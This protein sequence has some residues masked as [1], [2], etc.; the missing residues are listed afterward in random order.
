MEKSPSKRT[1]IASIVGFLIELSVASVG[2]Y[3][4]YGSIGIPL[5]NATGNVIRSTVT[6]PYYPG[7]FVIGVYLFGMDFSRKM[8]I[9]WPKGIRLLIYGGLVIAAISAP[10]LVFYNFYFSYT[11]VI[12]GTTY[13]IYPY[14]VQ[15]GIPFMI[16]LFV[17][18]IGW[19]VLLAS[20][21]RKRRT[22][23]GTYM[24]RISPKSQLGDRKK[25]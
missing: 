17:A 22:R 4:S 12:A 24:I 18:L 15:A 19:F 13:T 8:L 20:R 23:I 21:L 11:E 3:L 1:G 16:G 5:S 7:L 2:A 10:F 6:N 25:E 14:A 9:V